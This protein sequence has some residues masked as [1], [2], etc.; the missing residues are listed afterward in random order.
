MLELQLTVHYYV[1][2]MTALLCHS[3]DSNDLQR[4]LTLSFNT[5]VTSGIGFSATITDC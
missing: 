5:L 3:Y 4:S 1:I 2:H